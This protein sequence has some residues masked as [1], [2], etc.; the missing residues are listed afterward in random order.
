MACR[1]ELAGILLQ[2][3]SLMEIVKLI[4]S[5]VLPDDQKLVIEIARV[6]RVGFL[7][8][9]AF[10]KDDTFV[11]MEK[12]LK[13]M[14]V[15]LHLYHKCQDVVARQVPLSQIIK[16]GLFDKVIKIKY[17]VPNDQ[18]DLLDGYIT[19][20]NQALGQFLNTDYRKG[21]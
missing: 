10:H 13:M 18:L 6:V 14:Q 12:Q 11:P 20:I 1:E 9:N 3:N 17:D 4:G 16:L 2:E 5:D 7:Q 15:I 19:E 8:Q 21:E